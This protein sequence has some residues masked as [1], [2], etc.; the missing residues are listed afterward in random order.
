MKSLKSIGAGLVCCATL[1]ASAE[2]ALSPFSEFL[3]SSGD[4]IVAK[5]VKLAELTRFTALLGGAY[6]TTAGTYP[7]AEGWYPAVQAD[8]SLLVQF[9]ALQSGVMKCV[10][11]R[12]VQDGN[13][14]R[15]SAWDA[16]L[17]R[18]SASAR[19]GEY[20]LASAEK[21]T[22]ATSASANGYGVARLML[23]K[24]GRDRVHFSDYMTK[25]EARLFTGATIARLT[26]FSGVI[27]GGYSSYPVH[28]LAYRI[29]CGDSSCEMQ[30]Q[31]FADHETENSRMTRCVNLLLS[32]DS[33]DVTGH[34][35][36]MS[37]HS[38]DVAL[39]WDGSVEWNFTR[40]D[41]KYIVD[42]NFKNGIAFRNLE[43]AVS[44]VVKTATY[45]DPLPEAGEATVWR[46]V[47]LADVLA[48]SASST[49]GYRG[50]GDDTICHFACDGTVAS[51][52]V[53]WVGGGFVKCVKFS[54]R[55]DGSDV[56]AKPVYAR[57]VST[58]V[59]AARIGMDFDDFTPDG[60]RYREI[61]V[62][63]TTT[64]SGYGVARLVAQLIP[65]EDRD[66]AAIWKGHVADGRMSVASNWQ[67]GLV[68]TSGTKVFFRDP[69]PGV[70]EN[71]L[72]GASFAKVVFAASSP[73]TM[74][75]NPFTVD[76]V[77][78]WSEA[79]VRI[80]SSVACPGDFEPL[81]GGGLYISGLAV[82]GVLSPRGERSLET[83]AVSAD[84]LAGGNVHAWCVNAFGQRAAY[85]LNPLADGG[86]RTFA[87]LDADL[88]RR[89]VLVLQG[90]NVVTSPVLL[91]ADTTL[92]V[93][94]G[95]TSVSDLVA[96]VATPIVRIADGGQLHVEKLANKYATEVSFVGPGRLSFGENGLARGTKARFDGVVFAT[97]GADY[98]LP[99]SLLSV[100]T[101]LAIAPVD[102]DGTPRTIT[103]L[104]KPSDNVTEVKL[105]SGGTM[106]AGSAA[107]DGLDLTL[108]DGNFTPDG[109]VSVGRLSFE[110]TGTLKIPSGRTCSVHVSSLVGTPKAIIAETGRRACLEVIADGDGVTLVATGVPRGMSIVVR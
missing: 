47:S 92:F 16:R 68:P 33:A 28:A 57:A 64:G 22:V 77:E 17:R 56:K 49:G 69:M 11:V 3:T 21:G 66:G 90:T 48:V 14:I 104:G 76:V 41:D 102:P 94:N 100:S 93:S 52:Q 61:Q 50:Q 106:V 40:Y 91:R 89:E 95:V 73:V 20:D 9:Q 42:G 13:D 101:A 2:T 105:L 55:Q 62:V 38:K 107:V 99:S 103:L 78:N 74:S 29:A 46:G 65:P 26:D 54:L 27:S 86:V 32:N 97:K 10:I 1:V 83:G 80:E 8:G 35:D 37:Y 63:G 88:M 18:N 53:Q 5:D 19:E 98:E 25:T 87:E 79:P 36:W 58:T 30:M 96:P 82:S 12:F 110:G 39:G 84:A 51:A 43:A 81:V 31:G 59:T 70:I 109:D 75:G 72:I 85:A 7:V 23:F 34:V 108:V 45:E 6:I 15:A 60:N 67:D 24:A 44:P 71:D 4:Q